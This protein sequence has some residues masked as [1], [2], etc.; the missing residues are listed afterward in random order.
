VD[1]QGMLHR[2]AFPA[3]AHEGVD[4]GAGFGAGAGV[5]G[6]H[7]Q[8]L[9]K[10]HAGVFAQLFSPVQP[11]SLKPGASPRHVDS[12][13]VLHRSAFPTAAHKG[14]PFRDAPVG[15]AVGWAVGTGTF[16]TTFLQNDCGQKLGL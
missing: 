2:S 1:S 15:G 6:G 16:D 14:V 8:T 7:V 4:L 3:A 5:D 10:A 11:A 9:P 13:V 12:Q